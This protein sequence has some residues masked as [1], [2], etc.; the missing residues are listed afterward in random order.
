MSQILPMSAELRERTGTGGARETRRA[1]RV[2]AIVY[3]AGEDPQPVSVL[4]K[5]LIKAVQTGKFLS[6]L[7]ELDL[8]GAR[9][10]VIPRAV[11]FHP[12]T[13]IPVHV[14]FLRLKEGATITVDVPVHFT[15]Q[16]TSP[17]LKRG[18]VLN[19]VRHEVSLT[20][21]IDSIPEAI[22]IDLSTADINDSIHISAVTLPAGVVPTIT[23]R[24]FTIAT[25]VAPSSLRSAESDAEGAQDGT[26]TTEG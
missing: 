19:I 18:G 2:P 20:C 25:L 17:G 26:G 22:E 9:T 12:V 8:G 11:Q 24:D 15:G 21:P 23:D 14:D 13:D 1:A 10:R 6:T 5:D 7:Y 4:R 16:E 3:G